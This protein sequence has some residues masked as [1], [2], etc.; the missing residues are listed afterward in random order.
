MSDA[1]PWFSI[2]SERKMFPGA[3]VAALRPP[4]EAAGHV[5]L[6]V[7]DADGTVWS[8]YYDIISQWRDWFPIH[9]ELRVFP[10]AA[11]TALQT[12]DTHIDL[13]VTGRDGTVWS[14]FHDRG[15]DWAEWFAIHPRVQMFPGATI[16]ALKPP[17]EA[18]GHIDL[19]VTDA[20][21]TVW[22]T[23]FD[24]IAKWRD[25][26]PIHPEMRMFPG[27]TVTALQTPTEADQRADGRNLGA[28]RGHI[29]L[30]VTDADGYVWSTFHERSI[31]WVDWFQV[32]NDPWLV[33]GATV[34]VPITRI[35]SVYLMGC[36]RDGTMMSTYFGPWHSWVF[37]DPGRLMQPG[38][39]AAI[40][41]I[42]HGADSTGYTTGVFAVDAEGLV[43]AT[44]Y[45]LY[46]WDTQ[47][48]AAEFYADYTPKPW[49]HFWLPWSP[50]NPGQ[51]V[52]DPKA[53]VTTIQWDDTP[54]DADQHTFRIH[55][56]MF[57]TGRDGTVWSTFWATDEHSRSFR[58]DPPQLQ[59]NDP[60]WSGPGASPGD[61]GDGPDEPDDP[62]DDSDEGQGGGA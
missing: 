22:S 41:S 33:P 34:T 39:T 19:F 37:V 47:W 23:Y 27:A 14:T 52:V 11:V 40:P 61:G 9:P 53:T 38:A 57:A 3:T 6:F 13:F 60:E 18:A 42:I 12:S 54:D 25:W 59:P 10:G 45:A 7:T 15:R 48:E 62:S 49:E 58:P 32:G 17:T 44:E 2:H 5:D 4:G 51:R 28:K 29:D 20:N 30:F 16:T 26:F 35:G 43:W 50:I 24:T 56:D 55:T 8:T 1:V 31:D 36:N 21:G 46:S